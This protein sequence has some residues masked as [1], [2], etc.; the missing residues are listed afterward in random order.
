MS[1]NGNV[2]TQLETHKR[3]LEGLLSASPD[4]RLGAPESCP[5]PNLPAT[6]ILGRAGLSLSPTGSPLNEVA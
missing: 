6:H 3:S 4:L 2:S 1:G 5:L